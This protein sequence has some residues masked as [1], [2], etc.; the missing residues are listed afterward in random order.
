MSWAGLWYLIGAGGAPTT[1][2]ESSSGSALPS[3]ATLTFQ[4]PI[5]GSRID[6]LGNPAAITEPLV[7]SAY[8]TP[9]RN[10]GA[11]AQPDTSTELHEVELTGRCINPSSLPPSLLPGSKATAVIGDMEGEFY[12][13]AVVQSPFPAVTKALGAKLSGTFKARVVWGESSDV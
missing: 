6:D 2:T 7:M 4:V 8:L 13:A 1:P 9:K 5:G 10:S 11:R 3:N 12:L